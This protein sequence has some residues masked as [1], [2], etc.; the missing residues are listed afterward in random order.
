[1]AELGWGFIGA[2]KIATDFATVLHLI[3][4][5]RRVAVAASEGERAKE[6]A[7]KYGFERSYDTYQALVE[8]KDVDIVYC[9][10][11]HNFHY[12]DVKLALLHNK[13]VLCEKPFTL[14]TRQLKELIDLARAKNLF[15]MEAM[16]TRCFPATRRVL[17]LVHGGALWDIH[18][19]QAQLGM[20][21]DWS[22]E[23]L[24]NKDLGGGSALDLADYPISW[25]TMIYGKPPTRV[26]AMAE[27]QNEVDTQVSA[28]LDYGN[29]RQL[30]TVAASFYAN[31]PNEALVMGTKGWIRV[32][33]PFHA[34][35][36]IVIHIEG[37]DEVVEEF[38]LPDA[39]AEIG[40]DDFEFHWPNQQGMVYQAQHVHRCIKEK[41]K[42]S[43]YMPLDES[44]LVM[45]I[46]DK[47]REQIG[48]IY[49]A[50]KEQ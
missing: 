21:M 49:D 7:K 38:P 41:K 45:G 19:V 20:K 46:L 27:I 24:F 3:P 28:V 25:A 4:E 40:R 23:R 35:N 10:R 50:D 12:D 14:N 31:L 11:T 6:F 1:M 34:P 18:L 42:E 22:K 2:G 9:N 29:G 37:Q 30:A 47:V 13:H 16:W 43:P 26:S 39:L 5:A 8:D 32:C 44:V 33:A 36:K 15:M 17:E 48:V